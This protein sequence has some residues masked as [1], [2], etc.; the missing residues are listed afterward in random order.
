MKGELGGGGGGWS[1]HGCT[2]EEDDP[3]PSCTCYG[4][5][6]GCCVKPQ[7]PPT[8]LLHYSPYRAPDILSTKNLLSTVRYTARMGYR[9]KSS[10]VKGLK[11]PVSQNVKACGILE[12]SRAFS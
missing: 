8:P 10:T 3:P 9:S 11:F 7:D 12:T 5:G 1:T 4:G 2:F 6:E